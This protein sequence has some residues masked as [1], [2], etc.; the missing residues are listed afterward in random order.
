ML[1]ELP[2][3]CILP[4]QTKTNKRYL[5]IFYNKLTQIKTQGAFSS[6]FECYDTLLQTTVAVKVLLNRYDQ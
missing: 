5:N 1:D 6:V 4:K 3:F 2:V